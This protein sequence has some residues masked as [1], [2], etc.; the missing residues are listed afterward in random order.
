MAKEGSSA[1]ELTWADEI[2]ET[3]D[4]KAIDDI[5]AYKF[6]QFYRNLWSNYSQ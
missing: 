3:E 5:W 2:D 1:E 4:E 6:G